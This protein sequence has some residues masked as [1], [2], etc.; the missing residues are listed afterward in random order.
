MNEEKEEK[1][2]W[3]EKIRDIP[4]IKVVCVV[5]V[6]LYIILLI[7]LIG[8]YLTKDYQIADK[9]EILRDIL[10]IILAVAGVGI[11]ALG[12]VIYLFI[13]EHAQTR[14]DKWESQMDSRL[15]EWE[16]QIDRKHKKKR[17]EFLLF[18]SSMLFTNIGYSTWMIYETTKKSEQLEYAIKITENAY[19]YVKK[20]DEK[21]PS[22]ELLKCQILNNLCWYL[23]ERGKEEDRE[24]I[25]G[26]AEYIKE[27]IQKYPEKGVEWRDTYARVKRECSD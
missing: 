15:K 23:V 26:Y 16:S 20:L 4:K 12:Y 1:R 24:L 22:Y 14:L 2:T 11:A 18:S 19:S 9:Y 3:M 5:F 7:I 6:A 25:K 10:T 8:S 27:R 13:L 17:K 21:V